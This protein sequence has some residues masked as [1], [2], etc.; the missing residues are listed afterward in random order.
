MRTIRLTQNQQ[1][2]VDD[3]DYARLARFSWYACQKNRVW[4]AARK[5]YKSKTIYMHLEILGVEP[6]IEV[7]HKNH[8]GLDN[9]RDNL[10]RSTHRQNIQ[11]SRKRVGRSFKGVSFDPR[12]AKK[13]WY[14]RISLQLG[15]RLLLGYFATKEEA[16]HA[17][18][19]AARNVFGEFAV[20]NFL[21]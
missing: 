6:G 8:D 13:P 2:I 17:Y 12:K 15:K 16:A 20:T 21:V 14:A 9:R 4:Y 3:C 10:R 7:D 1:A 18:D 19:E 11:N 5:P